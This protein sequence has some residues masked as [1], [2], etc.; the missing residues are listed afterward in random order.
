MIS[1]PMS[2]RTTE[3]AN[4]EGYRI[5]ANTA[6]VPLISYVF[7]DEKVGVLSIN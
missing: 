4:V 1:T 3:E 6:I 7:A 2:R 5:P